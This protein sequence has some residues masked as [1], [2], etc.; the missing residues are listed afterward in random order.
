M[1]SNT[2]VIFNLIIFVID[3]F[4]NRH[5]LLPSILLFI[6]KVAMQSSQVVVTISMRFLVFLTLFSKKK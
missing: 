3:Q 5:N 4:F 1:H 2:F 6:N